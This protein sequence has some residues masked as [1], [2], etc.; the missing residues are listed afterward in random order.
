M[1]RQRTTSPYLTR[2]FK[3]TSSHEKRV[4]G[5]VHTPAGKRVGDEMATTGAKVADDQYVPIVAK[6]IA[7]TLSGGAIGVGDPV[8][9]SGLSTKPA[10]TLGAVATVVGASTH[11]HSTDAQGAHSHTVSG[12]ARGPARSTGAAGRAGASGTAG[13]SRAR[14]ANGENEACGDQQVRRDMVCPLYGE[15]D[16][17]R[18]LRV[19]RDSATRPA[20][21]WGTAQAG[22]RGP[23]GPKGEQGEQGPTGPQGPQ[24]RG[25]P[26][27]STSDENRYLR[28]VLDTAEDAPYTKL[29]WS[30]VSRG[31]RGPQGPAGPKGDKGDRGERGLVGPKGDRGYTGARGSDGRDGSD[32]RNESDGDDG[33]NGRNGRDGVRMEPRDRLEPRGRPT[34]WRSQDVRRATGVLR[35][36]GATSTPCQTRT[37]RNGPSR[38]VRFTVPRGPQVTRGNV[39]LRRGR[40]HRRVE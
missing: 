24:G 1:V 19:G 21:V 29:V 33:T 35:D 2:V 8:M 37:A 39:Q 11:S 27:H 3:A 40:R 30:D 31:A 34:R 26:S 25:V 5:I 20:L 6:G 9:A 32:G 28:V 12:I 38:P 16:V 23:A 4:V 7:K 18:Y 10:P 22:P 17:D 15:S 13:R 14:T 36:R